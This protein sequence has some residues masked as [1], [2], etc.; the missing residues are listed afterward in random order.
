MITIE[1]CQ[2]VFTELKADG[3]DTSKP[4]LWI[5]SFV[6]EDKRAL[7]KL[8]NDLA[9]QGFKFKAIENTTDENNKL[10]EYLMLH[11][12]INKVYDATTLFGQNEAFDTLA[13]KADLHLY[14]GFNCEV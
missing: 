1:E 9:K 6:D 4:L 8:S 7:E 3:I 12:T 11:I 13:D 10:T 14:Y 2:D 5:F